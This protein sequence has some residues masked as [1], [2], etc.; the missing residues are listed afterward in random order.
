MNIAI[1]HWKIYFN[2]LVEAVG[3]EPEILWILVCSANL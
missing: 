3:F 1:L 2:I